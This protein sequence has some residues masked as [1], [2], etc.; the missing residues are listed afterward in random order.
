MA[1]SFIGIETTDLSQ[2]T[3]KLYHI[4]L[5]ALP[6]SRFELTTSVVIGTDCI[7]SCK[8]NYHTITATTNKILTHHT[9]VTWVFNNYL[10]IDELIQI[11]L[12]SPLILIRIIL[13]NSWWTVLSKWIINTIYIYF[14]RI[15]CHTTTQ[16]DNKNHINFSIEHVKPNPINFQIDHT[17]PVS[18]SRTLQAYICMNINKNP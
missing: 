13:I 11:I 5:Y 4:M 3:D 6:W 7:C 17:I 16:I 14:Y 15:S 2:V 1:V 18:I 10:N 9:C 12:T 8:S